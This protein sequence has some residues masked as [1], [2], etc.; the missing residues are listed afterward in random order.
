MNF[1]IR[2]LLFNISGFR[3]ET[4]LEK[5]LLDKKLSLE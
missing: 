4:E 5:S 3:P 2:N 1:D